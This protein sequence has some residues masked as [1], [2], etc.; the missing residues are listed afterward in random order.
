MAQLAEAV[1]GLAVGDA[2]GVPFEFRARG[3]FRCDGMTGHG[4]HNQP[5]GTWSDDTS[6][7]LATCDSIREMGRVDPDDIRR[8]FE[9]WYY[10]GQYTIDGIFDIGNTCAA[11]IRGGKGDAN[12]HHCG[13]GSLMRIAPLAFAEADDAQIAAVGSLTH[14]N[15]TCTK[16]CIDYVHMLRALSDGAEKHE[17]AG[18]Y[19][20]VA[21]RSEAEIKSGGYV[22]DTMDAAVWCLLNTDS[23]KECVTLAVNLGDDTD[24][25]AAVAG[26]LAGTLYGMTGIP[27]EWLDTLLGKDI[28]DDCLF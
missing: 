1:Y 24:T 22:V 6:M 14:D 23:Y 19:A 2:L 3:S 20:H 17:A 15:K 9:A 18:D 11:A 16:R 10:D 25:T 4:T 21:S 26:A 27:E 12:P 28:I 8:R 13:N 7:T 5:A